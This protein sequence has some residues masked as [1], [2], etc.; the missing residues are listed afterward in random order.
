MSYNAA[1]SIF[2]FRYSSQVFFT[3]EIREKYQRII[4]LQDTNLPTDAWTV[5]GHSVRGMPTESILDAKLDDLPDL[6][7]NV[8]AGMT[9]Y[10]LLRRIIAQPPTVADLHKWNPHLSED[11]VKAAFVYTDDDGQIVNQLQTTVR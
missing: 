4:L 9:A 6:L 11:E 3:E 10:M 5:D 8:T 2:A 1:M 7:V